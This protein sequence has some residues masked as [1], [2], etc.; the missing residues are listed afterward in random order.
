MTIIQIL[1]GINGFY[2]TKSGG[3]AVLATGG[4]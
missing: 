1:L 4:Q 3:S 2:L